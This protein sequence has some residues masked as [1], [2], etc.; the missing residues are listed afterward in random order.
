LKS[1][2]PEQNN[3]LSVPTIG[4]ARL[5]LAGSMAGL[6]QLTSIIYMLDICYMLSLV[7]IRVQTHL[8]NNIPEIMEI[9][10]FC[11]FCFWYKNSNYHWCC[12]HLQNCYKRVSVL[13]NILLFGYGAI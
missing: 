8:I 2:P 6:T 1:L 9:C 5:C 4:N 10:H 11:L 12:G 3:I 7:V 13:K